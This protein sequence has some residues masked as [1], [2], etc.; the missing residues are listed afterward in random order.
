[1]HYSISKIDPDVNHSSRD[2][3]S[4]PSQNAPKM[5]KGE[6][7][8]S[9]EGYLLSTSTRPGPSKFQFVTFHKQLEKFTAGILFGKRPYWVCAILTLMQPEK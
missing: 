3:K 7:T 1:M 6:A 9:P 2:G 4:E 8:H 5:P